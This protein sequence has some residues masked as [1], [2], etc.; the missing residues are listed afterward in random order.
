MVETGA[1]MIISR[2]SGREEGL[3]RRENCT[4][5]VP[6]DGSLLQPEPSTRNTAPLYSRPL[7][8][9]ATLACC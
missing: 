8:Q 4:E 6:A 7:L 5:E 1:V 9:T 3:V 2:G